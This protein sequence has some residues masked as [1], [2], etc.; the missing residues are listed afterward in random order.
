MNITEESDGFF[1]IE[2][3]PEELDTVIKT[4]KDKFTKART[5][6]VSAN[7]YVHYYRDYEDELALIE[8]EK[9]LKVYI[10]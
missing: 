1:A 6:V 5:P 10:P 8:K 3:K 9:Y 7:I 2:C 4:I